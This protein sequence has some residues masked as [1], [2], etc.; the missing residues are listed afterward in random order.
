MLNASRYY[1][2]TAYVF[3]RQSGLKCM[4]SLYYLSDDRGKIVLSTC[5]F[6]VLCV[7]YIPFLEFAHR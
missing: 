5:I 2:L 1:V 6:L 4:A 3:Y 7:H